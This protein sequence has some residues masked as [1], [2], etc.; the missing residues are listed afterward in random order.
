MDLMK[1][2]SLGERI[3]RAAWMATREHLLLGR[4]EHESVGEGSPEVPA[5]R[6]MALE[7][8]SEVERVSQEDRIE[9]SPG[10]DGEGEAGK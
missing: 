4:A 5:S 1:Q 3:V 9:L 6:L 10:T 8:L 2:M 7:L